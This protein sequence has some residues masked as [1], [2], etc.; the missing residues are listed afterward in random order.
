MKDINHNWQGDE[1]GAIIYNVT[2][3]VDCRIASLWLQ[4][5]K[6]EHI[7]DIIATDCFT[8]ATILRLLET[9]ETEGPTYAVQYHAESKAFYNR[10][11]EIFAE[12]IRNKAIAKW[13]DQFI[14]FRS[15]LAVVN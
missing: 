5:M 4:W 6:K 13:G 10:Y 7:P 12:S 9:D 15:V 11:I 1:E 8:H 3:K 14:A 2:I